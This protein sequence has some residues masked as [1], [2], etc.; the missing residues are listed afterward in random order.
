MI[1]TESLR[2]LVCLLAVE[3]CVLSTTLA[4]APT[5][6]LHM[7]N[8]A[9]IQAIQEL[10]MHPIPKV[11]MRTVPR[12]VVE[13]APFVD[14]ELHTPNI[15]SND[16]RTRGVLSRAK[17]TKVYVQHLTTGALL[18]K[19]KQKIYNTRKKKKSNMGV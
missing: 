15:Q 14:K 11:A 10:F 2:W 4:T 13:Q 9:P 3:T 17:H 6:L 8:T 5:L 1:A 18:H 16:Q 7:Q 19:K 12:P